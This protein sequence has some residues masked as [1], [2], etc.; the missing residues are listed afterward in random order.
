VS[1][2]IGKAEARP[3]GGKHADAKLIGQRL[4]ANTVP[5]APRVRRAVEEKDRPPGQGAMV[6]IAEH[7]AI[8]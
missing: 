7:P 2:V 3:V 4:V 8:G 6:V 5:T 1:K